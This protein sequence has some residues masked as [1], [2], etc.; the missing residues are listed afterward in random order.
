MNRPARLTLAALLGVALVASAAYALAQQGMGAG[1]GVMMGR[2]HDRDAMSQGMG[3]GHGMMNMLRGHDT[4]EA[5]TEEL[6]AMFLNHTLIDR[7]VTNLPDGIRTVTVSDD[8]ELAA[9]IVA[10]VVGMIGRVEENRDPRLAIQSPT[11]DIL[12]R[13]HESIETRFE[14]VPNGIVVIQTSSDP[15]TVAALQQHAA[16]VTDMVERGMMA[17]HDSMMRRGRF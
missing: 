1:H 13:N 14:P 5:E 4:T 11:L 17:V 6:R 2:N 15:E 10:H 16:E 7:S 9:Q 8:P 12:F 3:M